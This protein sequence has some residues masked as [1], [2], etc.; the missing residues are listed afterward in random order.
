MEKVI[1]LLSE[2]EE[3]ADKIL[4]RVSDDKA[5]LNEEMNQKM[6]S[7][8]STVKIETEQKLSAL[9]KRADQEVEQEIAKMKKEQDEYLRQLDQNFDANCERYADEIFQHIITL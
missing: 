4:N 6:K 9:R 7:F 3:K 2:I 5:K 8:D 1:N